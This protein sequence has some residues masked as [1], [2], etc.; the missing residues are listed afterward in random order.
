M[1]VMGDLNTLS[2]QDRTFHE[3]INLTHILASSESLSSKFLSDGCIDYSP[4]LLLDEFGLKALPEPVASSMHK[5]GLRRQH[6][7]FRRPSVPT[8]L[9]Y[10]YM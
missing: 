10:D 4:L 7:T 5:H 1:I 6:S 2:R 8:A 3:E 9:L